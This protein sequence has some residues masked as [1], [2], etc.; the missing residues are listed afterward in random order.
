MKRRLQLKVGHEKDMFFAVAI[1][2]NRNGSGYLIYRV[3]YDRKK[4]IDHIELSNKIE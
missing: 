1:V 2:D 4:C 3:F